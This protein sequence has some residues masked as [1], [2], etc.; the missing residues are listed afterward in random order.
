MWSW[1]NGL[2]GHSNHKDLS[3]IPGPFKR[4]LATPQNVL[5]F[6]KLSGLLAVAAVAV[7]GVS[8]S[9]WQVQSCKLL[10]RQTKIGQNRQQQQQQQAKINNQHCFS[11]LQWMRPFITARIMSSFSR[12]FANVGC[13]WTQ[14]FCN[15]VAFPRLKYFLVR[16]SDCYNSRLYSVC[17]LQSWNSLSCAELWVLLLVPM[18]CFFITQFQ[19]IC[20]RSCLWSV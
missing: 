14:I 17:S 16:D 11:T 4:R 8:W 3:S 13:I 9:P 10:T 15:E 1:E 20:Y 6:M 5:P 18:Q 19:T 2:H 12:Y 7:D